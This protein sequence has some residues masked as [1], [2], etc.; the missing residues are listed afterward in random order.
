[1]DIVE[2]EIRSRM[3]AAI[4]GRDTKP[5]MVVRKALHAAGFRYRLHDKR[6]PGKP[7][8]VL[9][10]WR[11]VVLIHGCYW[12][13]HPGCRYATTPASN[14]EFWQRKFDHNVDRD[15]R[16]ELRL[17]KLGWRVAVIWEC[18]LKSG[19]APTTVSTLADWLQSPSRMLFQL[20]ADEFHPSPAG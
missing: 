4:K 1:M 2:P 10:K 11:A 17:E 20:S 6:L 3:M 7:D 13:R 16:D 8:I 9:P 18:Q 14:P 15:R 5:E 12:H 19:R